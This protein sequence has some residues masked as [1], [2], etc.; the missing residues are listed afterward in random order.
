MSF[1]FLCYFH[2][3]APHRQRDNHILNWRRPQQAPL[4]IVLRAK[5]VERSETRSEIYQI[6]KE[7]SHVMKSK[8][9]NKVL[10]DMEKGA[11]TQ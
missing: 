3:L 1:E 10:S 4:Q 11:G 8:N 5:R 9:N 6:G 7:K 2:H